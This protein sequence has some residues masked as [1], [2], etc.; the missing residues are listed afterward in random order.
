[1]K[2]VQ[3]QFGVVIS[4]QKSILKEI[5]NFYDNLCKLRDCNIEI[6]N[7]K[8][9]FAHANLKHIPNIQLGH[10]MSA[11]ELDAAVKKMKNNRWH[12]S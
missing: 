6:Y 5:Q 9:E 11:T 4:D 8:E 1:M 10:K 3:D 2:K 7:S 12:L